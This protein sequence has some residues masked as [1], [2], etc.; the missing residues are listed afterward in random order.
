MRISEFG[1]IRIETKKLTIKYLVELSY[2]IIGIVI[3][4]RAYGFLKNRKLS[5]M[6]NDIIR[7]RVGYICNYVKCKH[8]LLYTFAAAQGSPPI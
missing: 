2:P 7:Y 4:V 3:I 5:L 8:T 6:A 1:I